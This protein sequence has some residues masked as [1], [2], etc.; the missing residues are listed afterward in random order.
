MGTNMV[1]SRRL[2]CCGLQRTLNTKLAGNCS[3]LYN[4]RQTDPTPGWR[5]QRL[6]FSNGF[7]ENQKLRQ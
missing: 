1:R 2:L 7:A 3:R 6:R 4:S 5:G